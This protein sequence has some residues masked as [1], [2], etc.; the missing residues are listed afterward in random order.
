MARVEVYPERV[1]I[2]LTAAERALAM[3]RRDVVL[4]RAAISRALI[5]EDPLVWLHGVR[6]PG[7]HVPGKLAM[8]VWRAHSGKDFALVRVGRPA[9]VLDLERAPADAGDSGEAAHAA[10]EAF[11]D[12]ARVI[13]STTHA[14]E[15]IQALRLES[16]DGVITIDQ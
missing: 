7:T 11:D 12:F 9:V 3:R 6:A 8:G 4:D 10:L 16:E 13:L 14:A 5:T 2:K 1:V 15:L